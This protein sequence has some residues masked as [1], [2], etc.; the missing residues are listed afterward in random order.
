MASVSVSDIASRQFASVNSDADLNFCDEPSY[1]YLSKGSLTAVNSPVAVN[2][3]VAEIFVQGNGPAD[4]Q[5]G[6]QRFTCNQG[7]WIRTMTYGEA[8]PNHSFGPWVK[9]ASMSGFV[10]SV[11]S[12]TGAVVVSINVA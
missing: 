7:V 11:N 9:T 4:M 3:W 8:P 2:R 12:T 10:E 5:G 1:F 6:Y